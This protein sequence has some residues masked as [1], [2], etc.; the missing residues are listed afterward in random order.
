MYT[1]FDRMHR[2]IPRI[3]QR[4]SD[5]NWFAGVR[6]APQPFPERVTLFRSTEA[7]GFGSFSHDLWHPQAAGGVEVREI[8]GRHE[9][10]LEEPNVKLLAKD[11]MDCLSKYDGPT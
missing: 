2:P 11:V 4:A 7:V 3:L 8:S 5:I 1:F 6:Y 9:D 10:L